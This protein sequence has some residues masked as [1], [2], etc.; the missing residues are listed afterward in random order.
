MDVFKSIDIMWMLIGTV[1][2]FFMQAG[3]AMVKSL[4]M[5]SKMLSRFVLVRKAIMPYR[6]RLNT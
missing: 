6:M 2:V 4:S 3:F 5:M 1:L